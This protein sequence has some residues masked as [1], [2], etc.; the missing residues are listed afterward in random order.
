MR[1]FLPTLLLSLV[2]AERFIFTGAGDVAS[3][4]SRDVVLSLIA[5]SLILL[6]DRV[7]DRLADLDVVGR[8]H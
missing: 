2:L 4:L 8:F 6:V 7:G 3:M 5:L 1:S